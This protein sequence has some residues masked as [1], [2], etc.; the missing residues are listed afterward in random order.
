MKEENTIMGL[1]SLY[2]NTLKKYNNE[3]TLISISE[4]NNL[5]AVNLA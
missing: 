5:R 4:F 1:L 2:I 3:K